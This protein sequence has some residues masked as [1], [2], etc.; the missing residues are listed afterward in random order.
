MDGLTTVWK[1]STGKLKRVK[2]KENKLNKGNIVHQPVES[3]REV[4]F[5]YSRIRLTILIIG[6]TLYILS[7]STK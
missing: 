4:R 2:L 3:I 5:S 1:D 7:A 6:E